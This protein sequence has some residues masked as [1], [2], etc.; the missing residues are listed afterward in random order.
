MRANL[1][2]TGGLLLAERVSTALAP[3]LGRLRSAR[4]R[5]ARVREG[6]RYRTRA[7][8][9]VGRRAGGERAP[10]GRG[11]GRIARPRRIRGECRRVRRSGPRAHET[12]SRKLGVS[13]A[14]S[15]HH[16]VEGQPD[17]P[18]VV[19][20]NSL[21]STLAMWDPQVPALAERFRVVRYDHR[22]HDGSPVPT[23]PYELSD[24]AEDVIALLDRLEVERAH[25]C[26]MSLGGMVAMWLG[27]HVP[28]RID[29]LVLCSRR[30]ASGSPPAWLDRAAT[31]RAHGT[32][33]VADRVI[34]R[35]FTPGYA[36][37]NPELVGRMRA[38]I[39]GTPPEGYAACCELLASTDLRP[40]LAAIGAPTLLIAGGQDPSVPGC[41]RGHHRRGDPRLPRGGR[42]GRRASCE[43]RTGGCGHGAHPRPPSRGPIRREEP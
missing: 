2:L 7:R 31:V 15:V 18:V 38:M 11:C 6:R 37:G 42:R 21:G 13:P 16:V 36:D 3:A 1:D 41:R 33:A 24:L 26:G 39:A 5:R 29:R 43:R 19:L 28:D 22:G 9:R 32:D 17:A 14:V 8:G 30:R 25:I 23:G 10:L 27:A 20:S 12:P 4:R 40:D 35:W 34:G